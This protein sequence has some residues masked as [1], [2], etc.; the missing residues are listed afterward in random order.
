MLR[1]N[2]PR[3][4]PLPTHRLLSTT[5]RFPSSSRRVSASPRLRVFLSLLLALSPIL[6]GCI[7]GARRRPNLERI[8]AESRA[9]A[10]KRPLIVIPGVLGSQL[11]NYETNEVVWPSLF[12]SSDDGL[13]L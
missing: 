8:F 4:L 11:I 10:G 13:S 9:R 5:F 12:R 6:S 2:P 1:T 3:R 7:G